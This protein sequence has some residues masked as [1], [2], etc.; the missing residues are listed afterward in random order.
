MVRRIMYLIQRQDYGYV[1]TICLSAGNLV[2]KLTILSF[3]FYVIKLIKEQIEN[4]SKSVKKNFVIL[5]ITFHRLSQPVKVND[6]TYMNWVIIERRRQ[7]KSGMLI[8]PRESFYKVKTDMIKRGKKVVRKQRTTITLLYSLTLV[9]QETRM[10]KIIYEKRPLR[11][12]VT[13]RLA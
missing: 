3:N 11:Y 5:K 9:S 1:R 2:Q 13:G 7:A 12:R 8:V 6:A 10:R 4:C